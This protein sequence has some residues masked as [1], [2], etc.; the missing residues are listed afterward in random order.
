MFIADMILYYPTRKEHR[1]AAW[2]FSHIDPGG[3]TKDLCLSS[4]QHISD[5]RLMLGGAL[6]PVAATMYAIGFSQVYSG[7]LPP[8]HNHNTDLVLPTIACFGLASFMIVGGTY[9]ALFAYT[10]FL[11]KAVAQSSE[12]ACVLRA[13]MSKH[14]QYLKFVYK[15]AALPAIVGSVS[16]MYCCVAYDS[17]Y[18]PWMAILAPVISGPLKKCLKLHNVG[19]LVLA[20]GL[21][22]LWNLLFFLACSYFGGRT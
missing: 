13:L 16:F 6:G 7:L 15:W 12:Q 11:S 8:D 19:G 17:G 2:Y 10:G 18:P 20:G 9:H 14:Q 3:D 5:F 21:T 4:M 1:T 22:N